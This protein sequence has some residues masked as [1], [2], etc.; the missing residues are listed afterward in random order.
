MKAFVTAGALLSAML[1]IAQPTYAMD[2]SIYQNDVETV[3]KDE[4]DAVELKTMPFSIRFVGA[5]FSQ[6]DPHTTLIVASTNNALFNRIEAG[7][8]V[9]DVAFF[10]NGTKLSA[11][12]RGY[13]FL[14]LADNVH[15]QLFYV[16]KQF[17]NP[18]KA[19]SQRGNR[20]LFEWEINALRYNGATVAMR[21]VSI[22]SVFLLVFSDLNLNGIVDEN[23]LL[24]AE[25]TF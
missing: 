3:L 19:L 1:T 14:M 9:R 8:P 12:L 23:E 5:P 6:K 11:P 13:E 10:S 24:R 20:Y 21:Q 4:G 16:P 17:P 15:H 25:L 18:I 22:P 2:V 7:R